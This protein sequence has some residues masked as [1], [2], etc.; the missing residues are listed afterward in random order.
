M[1]FGK[2][3]L[4]LKVGI[5]V[6]IGL[7]I[8]AVFILSIGGMKT[9][10]SGYQVNFTFHFGNGIR[11]GAPVRFAGIDSGE[12]K[13]INFIF[14]PEEQKIQ[15]QIVCWIKR[16]VMIP[17]DST[18]WVNTLGLLGEKYIE[19]MPG[20]D[21][22][23]CLGKNESMVGVDPLAMHE[24]VRL[25]ND[26]AHNLDQSIVRINTK[27]GTIGKLL[28]DDSIYRELEA[29]IMDIRQHPWKL[30][31]KPKEKPVKK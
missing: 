31:F 30:F 15:I 24:L 18:I 22:Q 20:S 21:Y 4:E 26:I 23:H 11:V 6:F 13:S 17:L 14:M 28:Y 7:I 19:I 12:V 10:A 5:F 8:L 27:E 2:T 3:S 9:W 1:I 25:A 29:L 16:N